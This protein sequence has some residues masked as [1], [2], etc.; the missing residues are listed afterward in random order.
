MNH[1]CIHIYTLNKQISSQCAS[2]VR[3]IIFQ[4][5]PAQILIYVYLSK[6]AEEKFFISK[7]ENIPSALMFRY[8]TGRRIF[9]ITDVLTLLKANSGLRPKNI[10][11]STTMPSKLGTLR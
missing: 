2:F 10:R 4:F 9:N 6:P 5:S 11:M 3:T 1:Q 7:L 8:E